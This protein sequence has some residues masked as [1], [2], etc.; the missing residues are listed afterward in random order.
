M[1]RLQLINLCL[2]ILQLRVQ[3]ACTRL[4]S[5]PSETL[6]KFAGPFPHLQSCPKFSKTMACQQQWFQEKLIAEPAI[7]ACQ[8][9]GEIAGLYLE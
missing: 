2:C 5:G 4:W 7:E 9:R 8:D 3:W 1:N 6:L